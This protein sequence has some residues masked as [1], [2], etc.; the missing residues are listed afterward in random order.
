MVS[1]EKILTLFFRR[2]TTRKR[3]WASKAHTQRR[4]YKQSKYPLL[5]PSAFR[6]VEAKKPSLGWKARLRLNVAITQLEELKGHLRD[7]N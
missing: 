5:N 3:T 4:P 1:K 6:P 2:K 7:I